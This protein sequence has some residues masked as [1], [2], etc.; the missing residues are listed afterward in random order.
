MARI[1][2]AGSIVMRRRRDSGMRRLMKPC[3]T[4][5]PLM[6][7]TE[8]LEKPEASKANPKTI[9]GALLRAVTCQIVEGQ[10]SRWLV[11]RQSLR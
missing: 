7:P 5:C 8:E 9:A 6:V 2:G 1:V 4:S 10:R 3:M 11:R